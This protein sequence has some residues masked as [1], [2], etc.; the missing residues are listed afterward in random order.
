MAPIIFSGKSSC[1]RRKYANLDDAT[2]LALK[3][4]ARMVYPELLE[5][6]MVETNKRNKYGSFRVVNVKTHPLD[7]PFRSL[8][9]VFV[10]G[11]KPGAKAGKNPAKWRPGRSVKT[12]GLQLHI[13]Y[14]TL[15]SERK[16]V[17]AR[18]GQKAKMEG[19]ST[20]PS[21]YDPSYDFSKVP[22]D[23]R[24]QDIRVHDPGNHDPLTWTRKDEDGENIFGGIS[25][26][27]YNHRSKRGKKNRKHARDAKRTAI[28]KTYAYLAGFTLR[29]CSW[30][31]MRSAIRAFV[32]NHASLHR[33]NSRK[34]WLKMQFEADQAEQRAINHVINRVLR[35]K[36]P[37]RKRLHRNQRRRAKKKH[38]SLY[39]TKGYQG[40]KLV[41]VGDGGKMSGIKGTS[42]GAPMAKIK[43][44]ATQLSKQQD[45]HI[46][47]INESYTSKRSHCCKG[48][49][50]KC[51]LTGHKTR[52]T[53]DGRT[54]RATVHG[55][56]RCTSCLKLWNRD[57]SATLNQ[58]DITSEIMRTRNNK[59][60]PWWL[61]KDVQ[62]ARSSQLEVNLELEVLP[63]ENL[64]VRTSGSMPQIPNKTD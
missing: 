44:L 30:P 35:G 33:F 8:E 18:K 41:V 4:R 48:A 51:I 61:K 17:G 64:E 34:P 54:V 46:R 45:W 37:K 57:V 43:R 11:D 21:E 63:I 16:T 5:T 49:E 50:M 23:V 55:I 47:L 38:N 32:Q 2:V 29:T 62:I 59:A 26:A 24:E 27:E 15:N 53:R 22:R 40:A 56:S 14:E 42:C 31:E 28:D 58:W 39:S 20:K 12:N 7:P 13:T 9:S 60:R 25:K 1:F 10:L 3:A 6:T 36:G 52:T 19:H